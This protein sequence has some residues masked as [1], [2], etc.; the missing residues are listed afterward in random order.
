MYLYNLWL[1]GYS[2][3]FQLLNFLSVYTL[4][5]NVFNA[6]MDIPYRIQIF[7]YLNFKGL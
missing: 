4:V 3:F 5:D 1:N 6:V 7:L 2:A